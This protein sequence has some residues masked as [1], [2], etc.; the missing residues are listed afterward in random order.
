VWTTSVEQK[1]Q[2]CNH[3]NDRRCPDLGRTS[4]DYVIAF[5]PNLLPKLENI[6][7][8]LGI[9]V[10]P[11]ELLKKFSHSDYSLSLRLYGFHR[12]PL[13]GPNDRNKARGQS[14]FAKT[15]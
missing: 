7:R 10:F 2:A 6:L 4:G 8:E 11:R 5:P 13:P 12:F 15:A 1:I 3:V 9:Q 14:A